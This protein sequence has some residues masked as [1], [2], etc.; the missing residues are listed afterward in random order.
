MKTL[1]RKIKSVEDRIRRLETLSQ[2]LST[3]EDYQRSSDAKDVAERNL[4]VAIETCLDVGKIIISR[5]GLNEPKDN[6]GVFAA[7]AE[8]HILSSETLAFM[9]P[10]AGTRNILVHGYDKVDDALVYGILKRHIDDFHVFL[11]E[12]R[13]NFL[14][15]KASSS[16][17]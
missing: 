9:V 8:A 17:P 1:E 5:E 4:Q 3:F 13:D 12:V 11:K 10:M 6:K 2:A 15:R 16:S 14:I 7:L